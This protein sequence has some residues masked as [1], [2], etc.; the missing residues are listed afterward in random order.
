MVVDN[1]G[2]KEGLI[3][4]D[5]GWAPLHSHEHLNNY[6]QWLVGDFSQPIWNPHIRQ[7]GFIFPKVW[8]EHEK[9]CKSPPRFND[10]KKS[11]SHWAV[12]QM[13]VTFKFNTG[14]FIGIFIM[15]YHNPLHNTQQ[16]QNRVLQSIEIVQPTKSQ[17]L[18]MLPIF[19]RSHQRQIWTK[20]F[21]VFCTSVPWC[22]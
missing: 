15:D 2:K 11:D 4:R 14:W 19:S 22:V 10:W 12:K 20:G 1:P 21:H 18:K 5:W 17:P 3:S 16:I 7:A 13:L 9:T 8:D 6:Q